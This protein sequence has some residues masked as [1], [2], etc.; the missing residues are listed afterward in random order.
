LFPVHPLTY[1]LSF[2]NRLLSNYVHAHILN[3]AYIPKLLRIVRATLFPNNQPG[4]PREVPSAA[5]IV[6]IKR[7]CAQTIANVLPPAVGARYF[8]VRGVDAILRE[9]ALVDEVESLLDVLGD[10]YMNRHLVFGIVELVVVRVLPE[11]GEK[12]VS[13]LM[14]E[15][16]GEEK[17]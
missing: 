17:L 8:A 15:R 1:S 7:R 5:E 9:D 10:A 4:P 14:K 11:M 6:A 3:P 16:L 2:R 12:G 13:V